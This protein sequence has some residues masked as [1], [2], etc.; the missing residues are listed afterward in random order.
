LCGYTGR[1]EGFWPIFFLLVVLKIPVLSALWL[2]WWASKAPPID[3]TAEDSGEGFNRWRPL[4]TPP[5]GPHPLKWGSASYFRTVPS[6]S[7]AAAAGEKSSKQEGHPDPSPQTVYVQ[8]ACVDRF[9]S[10]RM[11]RRYGWKST[12]MVW[13]LEAT[14]RFFSQ[15]S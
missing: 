6:A 10:R 4:P 14:K 5:R 15:R 2:V 11:S 9:L 8:A 7:A 12:S 13:R 3:D 1:M